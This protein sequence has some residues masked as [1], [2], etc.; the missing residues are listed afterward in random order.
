MGANFLFVP[1]YLHYL[2]SEQYAFIAIFTT[3]FMFFSVL[4][5]GLSQSFTRLIA[6]YRVSEK[7]V[8]LLA[9]LE[10][11]FVILVLVICAVWWAISPFLVQAWLKSP[12]VAG[13]DVV[14]AF[15]LIGIAAALS[16]LF[17]VYFS[18]FMGLE[19]QGEANAHFISLGI[20]RNV[21]VI[22]IIANYPSIYVF[23]VWFIIAHI[24][25]TFIIRLRLLNI[26]QHPNGY[27]F[28]WD[29]LLQ[30]RK[31]ASGMAIIAIASAIIGQADKI[32]IANFLKLEELTVYS[33]GAMMAQSP[34]IVTTP[35]C[36]AM[37]PRITNAIHENRDIVSS[38]KNLV[39]VVFAVG[40]IV[41]FIVGY[42]P[43]RLLT[44]W[45][46]GQIK[47][48]ES[49]AFIRML[50]IANLGLSL[51]MVSFQLA[52]AHGNLVYNK[53]ASIFSAIIL[54]PCLILAASVYGIFGVA[55]LMAVLMITAT[56]YTNTMIYLR[57]ST[58]LLK[59]NFLTMLILV[60]LFLWWTSLL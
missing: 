32:V 5:L 34:V 60:S 27:H 1:I 54:F 24:F 33:L 56:A 15:R 10:K 7:S 4:D 2:G 39:L 41:T 21:F 16:L 8:R 58:S 17:P 40:L 48:A 47:S 43:S 50:L 38:V 19:R 49:D 9:T 46:A 18:G 13:V 23:F 53:N 20:I 31:F 29:E 57:H 25:S 28:S 12:A 55:L 44:F 42:A 37:L 36:M 11:V 30:V 51:Q 14:G 35:I 52:I 3:L 59:I 26:L 45:T 22:P 6:Q